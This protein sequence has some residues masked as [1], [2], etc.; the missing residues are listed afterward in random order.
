[1]IYDKTV[2]NHGLNLDTAA[3]GG[4]NIH[5]SC[6]SDQPPRVLRKI[7]C[8]FMQRSKPMQAVS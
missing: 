4:M 3:R 6:R 1:M 7:P 2:S 8:P 5:L